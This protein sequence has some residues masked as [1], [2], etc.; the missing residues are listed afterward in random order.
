MS[1]N[2][3]KYYTNNDRLTAIL[4]MRYICKACKLRRPRTKLK[5][6]KIK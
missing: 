2:Q 6:F 5:K 1:I 3:Q 4:D